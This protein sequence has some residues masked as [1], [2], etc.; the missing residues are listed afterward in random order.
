MDELSWRAKLAKSNI[1][2]LNIDGHRWYFEFM[3]RPRPG[4]IKWSKT[5]AD[6]P[7]THDNLTSS[8]STDDDYADNMN[9]DAV[10]E[11]VNKLRREL[12]S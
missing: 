5:W 2:I 6:V 8:D 10:R 12:E 4:Q 3:Y 9:A 1:N 11:M 7:Y